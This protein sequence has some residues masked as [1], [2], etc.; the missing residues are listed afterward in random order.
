MA[1]ISVSRFR[2]DTVAD[3][4][5]VRDSTG[6]AVD[7]TGFTFRLTV[8]AEKAPANTDNQLF[9]IDG[10]ITDEAGGVVEFAPTDVQADQSPGKYFFDVEMTDGNGR[11]QTIVTGTYVFRQ[12][13]SK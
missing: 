6:N 1:D 7:I 11:I 3:E 5:V 4:F 10:V 2:G 9:S 8:N 13:I 12:D